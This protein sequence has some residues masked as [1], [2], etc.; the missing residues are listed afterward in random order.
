MKRIRRTFLYYLCILLAIPTPVFA[1]IDSKTLDNFSA[2]NIMFYDPSECDDHGGTKTCTAKPSGSDITWIGDSYTEGA[3]SEIEAKLS[4]VDI[5][6]QTDK[7]FGDGTDDNPG[8]LK[9]LK[10]LADDNKVRKYVVMALGTNQD[11]TTKDAATKKFEEMLTTGGKDKTYILMK[12]FTKKSKDGK[13][14]YSKFNEAVV[15]FAKDNSNILVADW[16]SAAKD[17]VDDFY[18]SD[19]IHPKDGDGYKTFVETFYNALPGGCGAKKLNGNNNAEKVWN[20]FVD[21][22]INGVSDNAAVI[23]GIIGNLMTESGGHTYNLDPFIISTSGRYGL[24]QTDNKDF[25]EYVEKE[26]GSSSYWGSKNVPTD[27]ND[28]AIIAELDWL[29][30]S[31][32]YL[33]DQWDYFVKKLSEVAED[34]PESY[35]ELFEVAVEGA[36]RGNDE[37]KDSGVYSVEG[38]KYNGTH[39]KWQDMGLRRTDA[40][41]MY[42]DYANGAGGSKSDDT[43]A[44]QN[45]HTDILADAPSVYSNVENVKLTATSSSYTWSDGWLTGGVPGIAKE[46]VTG[47]TLNE[48]LKS[49]YETSDGKPNKILIHNT[50]GTGNGFAAYG[51]NKFPAHFIVDLKKQKGYQN[52]PISQPALATKGADSSTVQI[53]VVGFYWGSKPSN[54]YDLSNFSANEWDYLA[55]LLAAIAQETGISLTTQVEWSGSGSSVRYSGSG[56]DF[57]DKV[58]G[59]VGH[60]HSP[61]DD[62]VDPGDIWDALNSAI[63]RNPDASKFGGTGT[64]ETTICPDENNEDNGVTIDGTTI[65]EKAVSMA[66]PVQEDGTCKNSSGGSVSWDTNA[67]DCYSTAREEYKT[68]FEKYKIGGSMLDCGHFVATVVHS[69]SADDDF[70]KGGS[71]KMGSHMKDSSKWKTVDGASSESDLKPGDIMWYDGHIEIYVGSYGGKYGKIASASQDDYVG[72]IKNFRI[73]RNGKKAVVYRLIPQTSGGSLVSGG[74]TLEQAKTFMEKY[75]SITPRKYPNK[76]F[77]KWHIPDTNSCTS[78]LENCV[79]FSSWFIYEYTTATNL[80]LPNGGQVVSYLLQSNQGFTDG[81]HTPKPYAVF[82]TS[83]GSTNCGNT[84]CGHTGVVLGIDE[85]NDKIIIGEAGCSAGFDFTQAKEKKLSDF[86]SKNYTY[87]YTDNIRK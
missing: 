72:I 62:H 64:T 20:Y 66:W 5:T 26:V 37:I 14:D 30:T 29:L 15:E 87:A 79:A 69:T 18:K 28:K 3:K 51:T 49:S 58:T 81:G 84:K 32:G 40:R 80:D 68:N 67:K 36:I 50:E 76:D 85:K 70:P 7:V 39:Y 45:T 21:A 16:E 31:G 46:D 55:V 8:G 12:P 63:S 42:D 13:A 10:E 22:N 9:I 52:I 78:D 53:E 11:T 75:R 27:I 1:K 34:K 60:M 74:M 71:G 61:T 54:D 77:K 59:I 57:R 83:S 23:A 35:A 47:K 43:T 82:S 17:H 48:T 4:G 33:S 65:A 19:A 6:A 56:E 41:K 73:E 38:K 86:A 44:Y 2:N 25:R 24:F